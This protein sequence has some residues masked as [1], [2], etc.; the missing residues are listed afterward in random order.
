[1][2]V[3]KVFL[4]ICLIVYI[5]GVILAMCSEIR[6]FIL[7]RVKFSIVI[8]GRIVFEMIFSWLYIYTF[9]VYKPKIDK[10]HDK[11]N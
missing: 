8:I 10:L 3:I 11:K 4:I 6:Y 5:I 1:M 9:Y 2:I 7:S